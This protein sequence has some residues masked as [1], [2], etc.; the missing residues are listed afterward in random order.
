MP[1]ILDFLNLL[2]YVPFLKP[3]EEQITKNIKKIKKRNWY[4]VLLENDEYR[5]LII[6][7][8]DVRTVIGRFK[9]EKL[10]QQ[11]YQMKCQRKLEAILN[12]KM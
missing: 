11:N 2:M 8:K 4:K 7:N 3:D 5:K 6:Y 9:T 10:N 12:K 1:L